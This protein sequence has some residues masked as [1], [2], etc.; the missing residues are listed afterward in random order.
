VSAGKKIL[1]VDYGQVRVGLAVSDP[2]RKFAFPLATYE[3]RGA[4]R[5]AAHFRALVSQEDVGGLLV[6]L[7]VHLDGREGQKAAE[8]RAFGAWLAATTG[9][10]VLFYDERF[11]TVQAESAL[12][13]AGLTHRKRRSRRDMVAAQILLQTYLDAGCPPEQAPRAL[14]ADE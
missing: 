4:E 6:G 7:P 1:A 12:W 2:D 5:D 14:D 9:L 11:T 13:D 8:A 10:P 3:R